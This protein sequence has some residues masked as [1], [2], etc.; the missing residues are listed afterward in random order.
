MDCTYSALKIYRDIHLSRKMTGH[1][2]KI[3][4]PDIEDRLRTSGKA[5]AEALLRR[6]GEYYDAKTTPDAELAAR[7]WFGAVVCIRRTRTSAMI[8]W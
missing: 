4:C 3:V 1:P 2:V 5:S 6:L 8:R 7:P